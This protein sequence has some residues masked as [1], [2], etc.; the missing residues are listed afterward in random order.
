MTIPISSYEFHTY[1]PIDLLLLMTFLDGYYKSTVT[2]SLYTLNLK[3]TEG[4]TEEAYLLETLL[5]L[6]SSFVSEGRCKSKFAQVG[7]EYTYG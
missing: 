7:S 1:P 5:G 4:L 6:R 3:L 2:F